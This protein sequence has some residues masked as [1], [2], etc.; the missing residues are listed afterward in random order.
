MIGFLNQP[1]H[2]CIISRRN[3]L[4]NSKLIIWA[5]CLLLAM[6][7]ACGKKEE[8]PTT[9]EA[10]SAGAGTPAASPFDPATGTAAVNG[11][12]TFEGTPPPQA[13]L[14]LNADPVCV[15]L[16][17]EPVYAEEVVAENGNLQN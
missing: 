17:K 10:P 7:V 9:S 1:D 4:K 11:K 15:S 6:A 13:Q 8:T 2:A 12:V 3:R 5:A 14:K 16:H